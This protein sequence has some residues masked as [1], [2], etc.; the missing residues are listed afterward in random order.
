MVVYVDRPNQLAKLVRVSAKG[1]NLLLKTY[2]DSD[3]GLANTL[4]TVF[5]ETKALYP[6]QKY[7]LVIWSHADGWTPW[8]T[9][10]ATAPDNSTGNAIDIDLLAQALPDGGLEHI[11]FDACFMGSIEVFYQLRNKA[12]YLI[13]SPTEVVMASAYDASGIPYH[14]VLPYLLSHEETF[15]VTA[16]KK[17]IQ[18]YYEKPS[19]STL[20]SVSIAMVKTSK[21]EDLYRATKIALA[22]K[23]SSLD[24]ISM[25]NLQTYHRPQYPFHIYYDLG[26]VVNQISGESTEW[27]NAHKSCVIYKGAT[28]RF[29]QSTKLLFR[30]PKAA[31]RGGILS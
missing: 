14:K 30:K 17:Y 12:R 9:T 21:L 10:R 15:L 8:T 2:P 25:D 19:G 26:D 18:H 5:K 11:W 23:S 13:G 28:P 7:G 31:K 20:Q 6:N 1:E 27:N 3:S 22:N 29:T 24:G 4:S 16:C